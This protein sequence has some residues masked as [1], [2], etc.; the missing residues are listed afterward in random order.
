MG[1]LDEYGTNYGS[2]RQLVI[3]HFTAPVITSEQMNNNALDRGMHHQ[4]G[5]LNGCFGARPPNLV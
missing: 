5:A 1:V 3:C 2:A 4:L